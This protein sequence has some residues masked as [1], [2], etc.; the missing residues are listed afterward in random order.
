MRLFYR[1]TRWRLPVLHLCIASGGVI[2]AIGIVTLMPLIDIAVGGGVDNFL[3][4]AVVQ[5]LA[6]LG[7]T[8][9][10]YNLLLV[11]DS[12]FCARGALAFLYSF[13]TAQITV[14]VRRKI[15]VEL[16]RQFCDMRYP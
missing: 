2:E 7:I 5:V 11:I 13:I 12:I 6:A 1:R 16:T 15:Q 14:G 10:L 9:T 8:P 4:R 3:F